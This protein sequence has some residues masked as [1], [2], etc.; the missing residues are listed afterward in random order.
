M[1]RFS[2]QDKAFMELAMEQARRALAS[3]ETPVG[4][5]IVRDG[6]IVSRGHNMTN[7]SR[8]GTRHAEMV[9]IDEILAAGNIVDYFSACT[10]YVSCEPCIM[11]AGALGLLNF[12]NVVYGCANDKFGGNGSILSIHSGERGGCGSGS[13]GGVGGVGG[14]DGCVGQK[15]YPSAGGLMRDDAVRLLQE[16]YISGN[17]GAPTPHRPVVDPGVSGRSLVSFHHAGRKKDALPSQIGERKK[18]KTTTHIILNAI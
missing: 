12:R 4:C 7:A 14:E 1:R 3:G 5:V 9:A 2:D 13:L 6:T 15:S 11:C 18:K 10:L 8:N 17:P 16:F